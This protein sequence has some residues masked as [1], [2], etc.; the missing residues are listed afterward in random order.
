MNENN[1]PRASPHEYAL[2]V[3]V[4]TFSS[5]PETKGIINRFENLASVLTPEESIKVVV[6]DNKS[7]DFSHVNRLD[8]HSSPNGN[9]GFGA[10]VN[11]VSRLYDYERLLLLNFDTEID[12]SKFL[13]L[14]RR[15]K[16]LPQDVVWSPLLVNAD[17]SP[18]T[19]P[20][21]LYMRTAIQEVFDIFG[22]PAKVQRRSQPLHYLRGAVF[23]I[24]REMLELAQGFDERFFLYG[25]EADLCFRLNG[26]CDLVMDEDIQV[27]HHGS[28]GHK[29]KSSEALRHSLNAR[30]L[31]HRK[32]NGRIAGLVVRIA[33]E[34]VKVALAVKKVSS[35]WTQKISMAGNR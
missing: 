19:L 14:V 2:I 1:L 28:Q 17:G 30:V 32:Y 7:W 34:L 27:V 31:L 23:S 22:Y 21:S 6:W 11:A 4:I 25:E 29:G 33:V 13:S 26:V 18:Q 3:L 24:S 8:Y 5:L 16:Q 10:A 12:E 9:I 20:G 35:T 15:N